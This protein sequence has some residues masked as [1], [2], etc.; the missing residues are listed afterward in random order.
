MKLDCHPK[1]LPPF[2]VQYIACIPRQLRLNPP[3]MIAPE[4]HN[5]Q[6]HRHCSDALEPSLYLANRLR[7]IQRQQVR[8]E[9]IPNQKLSRIQIG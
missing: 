7:P 9:Q 3:S 8:L 1:G 2:A 6:I 5:N 4:F